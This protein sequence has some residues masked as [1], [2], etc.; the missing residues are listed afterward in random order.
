MVFELT[1]ALEGEIQQA[2]ENQ[3]QTFL[4]DARNSTLVPANSEVS[5]N[6]DSFYSL[7]EWNS[8]QGFAL[9]EDFVSTF[10]LKLRFDHAASR[11]SVSHDVST[12]IF[13]F[14]RPITFSAQ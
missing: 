11:Y 8:S 13:I 7:P 6:E 1:S 9:R 2:L 4:V 12:S 10:L 14:R 5:E 3:D